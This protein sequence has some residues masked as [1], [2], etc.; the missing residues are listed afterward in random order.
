[1]ISS[2]L[3][4]IQYPIKEELKR[5]DELFKKSLKSNVGIVDL[6]AKYILRQKGK[7]IRPLLVMLSGKIMGEISERTYRGAILVELLHTDNTPY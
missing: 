6:V 3:A 1:M 4:E 2:P 7:K 5:F